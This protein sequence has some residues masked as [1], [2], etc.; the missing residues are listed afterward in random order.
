M[1]NEKL[2][3][4]RE[5]V[6]LLIKRKIHFA[7]TL[8]KIKPLLKGTYTDKDIE[9]EFLSIHEETINFEQSNPVEIPEDYKII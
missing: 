3:L 8:N 2:K 7:S 9:S 1:N 5:L 4:G 6:S